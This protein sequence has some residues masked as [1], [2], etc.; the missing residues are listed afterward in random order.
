MHECQNW[1]VWERP[2]SRGAG[3]PTTGTQF[4]K[5]STA[6]VAPRSTAR[7]MPTRKVVGPAGS[8]R[9]QAQPP[10]SRS[11]YLVFELLKSIFCFQTDSVEPAV[12]LP[13]PRKYRFPSPGQGAP[14]QKLPV[15][16]HHACIRTRRTVLPLQ[17]DR[18]ALLAPGSAIET[19][20]LQRLREQVRAQGQAF[21]PWDPH[22]FIGRYVH[23]GAG[24]HG[25]RRR[26][27]LAA[28]CPDS[29][30]LPDP[31]PGHNPNARRFLVKR[32]LEGYQPLA[33]RGQI[34]KHV[35]KQTQDAQQR[36]R[37]SRRDARWAE[38]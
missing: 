5:R 19:S 12:L 13:A 23:T 14:N 15:P 26:A 18:V 17:G 8:T 34:R 20:A 29:S 25:G 3:P 22:W 37:S 30:S 1:R 38:R 10:C 31:A 7:G 16:E 36:P 2:A 9:R 4:E 24:W 28:A 33:L 27:R 21:P 11:I 35:S 32:S 6:W